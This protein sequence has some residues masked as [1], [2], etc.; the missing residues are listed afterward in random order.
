L[1]CFA[2][3]G[4]GLIVSR[5]LEAEADV[6]ARDCYRQTALHGLASDGDVTAQ[7]LLLKNR[8]DVNVHDDD[9]R[10]PLHHAAI[11]GSMQGV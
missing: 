4:S 5:L 7:R 3:W 1:F 11:V 10:T 6:N 9:G 2:K 8:A